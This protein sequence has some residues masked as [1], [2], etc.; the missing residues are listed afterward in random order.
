MEPR[1]PEELLADD[2]FL[3]RL[4]R[5]LVN[6]AHAAEDAAQT[7]WTLA[8]S[9]GRRASVP[10]RPWLASVLRNCV[11]QMR[12]ATERRSRRE[13]HAPRPDAQISTSEIVERE[14]ARKI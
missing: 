3:R 11:R 7:T 14:A 12:R 13:Q 8:L 2:A 5:L 1:S 6:D 9:R 4:A 10:L